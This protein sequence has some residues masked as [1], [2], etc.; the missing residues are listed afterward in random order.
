ELIIHADP[1]I[2]ACCRYCRVEKCPIRSEPRQKDVRWDEHI[3]SKN[4]KHVDYSSSNSF[5]QVASLVRCCAGSPGNS[6]SISAK[7]STMI[8]PTAYRANHFL[9]AGIMYQG[10][11]SVAVA[12]MASS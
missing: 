7:V 8:L 10:E 1:C 4:E 11:A 3:L 2:P 6:R 9:S 5:R 12:A